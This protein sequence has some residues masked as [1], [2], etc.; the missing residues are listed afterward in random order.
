[1][2]DDIKPGA[3]QAKAGAGADGGGAQ[4][5][6]VVSM[7]KADFDAYVKTQRGEESKAWE[8][9]HGALETELRNVKRRASYDPDKVAALTDAET[10]FADM[11]A[12][13]VSLGVPEDD[14]KDA[15]SV[16]DLKLL[17]RG[18]KGAAVVAVKGDAKP[19]DV[20]DEFVRFQEWQKAQTGKASEPIAPRGAGV[21]SRP[22][23]T[24][25]NI[26][27]LWLAGQVPGGPQVVSDAQYQKFRQTG[28]LPG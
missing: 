3:E 9:K 11:K 5:P 26:D 7:S 4:E 22:Q 2:A 1:M 14:I 27:A 19:G 8:T 15:E 24:G 18:Y 21:S 10:N 28:M 16:R 17:L 23:V 13:I 6:E 25:D 12:V 20:S